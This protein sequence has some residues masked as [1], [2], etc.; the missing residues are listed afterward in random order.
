MVIGWIADALALVGYEYGDS[1]NCSVGMVCYAITGQDSVGNCI[2]HSRYPSETRN[3]ARWFRV[4]TEDCTQCRT[5]LLGTVPP[6]RFSCSPVASS[7]H[8]NNNGRTCVFTLFS[9]SLLSP[10]SFS[11]PFL[12]S[13]S[14]TLSCCMHLPYSRTRE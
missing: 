5:A 2:Y 12:F 7:F 6:V 13:F 4:S 8:N 14:F 1:G 3:Y 9:S 11:F 10:H